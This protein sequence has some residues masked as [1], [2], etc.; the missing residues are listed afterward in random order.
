MSFS[1][2]TYRTQ[3][4]KD[5]GFQFS[6][7]VNREFEYPEESFYVGDKLEYIII[8]VSDTMGY[9]HTS[10]ITEMSIE[11]SMTIS[12]N[13]S[14]RYT[15]TADAVES[16]FP[17]YFYNQEPYRDLIDVLCERAG[18]NY[19]SADSIPNVYNLDR[20]PE[21]R[22]YY[23]ALLRL[24]GINYDFN[25]YPNKLLK[26]LIQ[27]YLSIRKYRGTRAS[28]LAML[29]CMDE[30]FI[31]DPNNRCALEIEYIDLPIGEGMTINRQGA[32]QI[33]YEN[34]S[35]DF[36]DHIY[37]MLGKVIPTGLYYRLA[38]KKIHVTETITFLDR[39]Y[40]ED[41]HLR[42]ISVREDF[43]LLDRLPEREIGVHERISFKDRRKD[44]FEDNIAFTERIRIYLRV[45]DSMN[46][47][48][49]LTFE[50][51]ITD[52]WVLEDNST[53]E[54]Y[55]GKI[56]NVRE[57][58]D[59]SDPVVPPVT[60]WYSGIDTSVPAVIDWPYSTMTISEDMTLEDNAVCALETHVREDMYV[61]PNLRIRDDIV[62]IRTTDYA[63]V[64]E[65]MVLVE[66]YE[67]PEE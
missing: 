51:H 54:E 49:N 4:T 65:D 21:D 62:F 17:D 47:S 44:S 15:D 28:I 42:T 60:N 59:W 33:F 24:I 35:N 25:S 30:K 53:K 13:S 5:R 10:T 36:I 22:R 48:D 57:N 40:S 12:E 23:N 31:Q 27:N 7:H 8:K 50:K 3:S 63:G 64:L 16:Y 46:L 11:D 34:I 43:Y 38:H 29:R 39:E 1:L 52:Q 45:S 67:S 37:Y 6:E 20:I 66:V 26:Y 41:T 18:Y 9:C 56:L 32:I 58:I 61:Q 55:E 2:E 19:A 14:I